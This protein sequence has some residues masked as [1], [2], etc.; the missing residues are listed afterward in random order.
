MTIL[1]VLAGLHWFSAILSIVLSPRVGID[2][3]AAGTFAAAM[4]AFYLLADIS[5]RIEKKL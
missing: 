1:R 3:Y 4:G 5:V 2:K